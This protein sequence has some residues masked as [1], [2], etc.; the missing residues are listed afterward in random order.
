MHGAWW[1]IQRERMVLGTIVTPSGCLLPRSPGDGIA[2]RPS[3]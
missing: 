1:Q 2:M 3:A